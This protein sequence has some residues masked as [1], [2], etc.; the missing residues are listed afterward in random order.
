MNHVIRSAT[1]AGAILALA[2]CADA[3]VPTASASSATRN[4]Q[5]APSPQQGVVVLHD[6][7]D[8]ATFNAQFGAGTC[9]RNGPGVPLSNF[10]AKVTAIQSFPSWR[11]TPT[12]LN[13]NVGDTFSA[14]NIGG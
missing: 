7:C 12:D 4:A 2:A 9:T 5:A 8:P 6:E 1:F 14:K 11:M 3:P 10:V 13:M